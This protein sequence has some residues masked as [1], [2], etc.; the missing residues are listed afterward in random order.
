[1]LLVPMA[2][3]MTLWKKLKISK[4]EVSLNNKEVFGQILI[5][6]RFMFVNL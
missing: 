2:E 3:N 5:G 1:M 6:V 4:I